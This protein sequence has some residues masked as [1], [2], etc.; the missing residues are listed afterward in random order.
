MAVQLHLGLT[1]LRV[2]CGALRMDGEPK[3]HDH[4]LLAAHYH[5]Q[6]AIHDK[7]AARL[8]VVGDHRQAADQAEIALAYH[9]QAA[10]HSTAAVKARQW[11]HPAASDAP[12]DF[13]SGLFA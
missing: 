9:L 11:R 6:A 1:G 13:G 5:E 8:D 12:E 3:A 4:H 10:F 2:S 7:A